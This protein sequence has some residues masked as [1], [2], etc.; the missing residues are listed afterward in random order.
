MIK[1]LAL[2]YSK[3][4]LLEKLNE[5]KT[6]VPKILMPL[7]IIMEK[8]G[9]HLVDE[10]DIKNLEELQSVTKECM[11][12]LEDKLGINKYTMYYASV[13]KTIAERRQER[14]AKRTRLEITNPELASNKKLKKHKK[15]KENR[16][17]TKDQNGY[18]T[19]NH[20]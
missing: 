12:I 6:I 18:Y 3:Y 2:I 11:Q 19:R 16:K 4:Y 5:N 8:D 20:S 15:S 17:F 10:V 7:F 13:N 14:K 1:L 9:Y